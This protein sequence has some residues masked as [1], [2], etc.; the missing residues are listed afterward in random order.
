MRL[1]GSGNRLNVGP[2]VRALEAH[3]V[4]EQV[5][6]P[7]RALKKRPVRGHDRGR[8]HHARVY[9]VHAQPQ[10]RASRAHLAQVRALTAVADQGR[11]LPADRFEVGGRPPQE[12]V[13]RAR[14]HVLRVAMDAAFRDVNLLAARFGGFR[15]CRFGRET[16]KQQRRQHL[17]RSRRS[18]AGAVSRTA[19]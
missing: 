5:L 13:G 4:G 11:L 3:K 6:P 9:L 8:A 18:L 12:R 14:P 1:P 2:A 17:R 15:G 7:W 16:A 19:A 10:G